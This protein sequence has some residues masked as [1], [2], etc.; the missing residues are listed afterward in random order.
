MHFRNFIGIIDLKDGSMRKI[1][2]LFL[3][4]ILCM[5]LCGC[6]SKEANVLKNNVVDN[7]YKDIDMSKY[8]N[9]GV[10]D[11]GISLTFNITG[12]EPFA[13]GEKMNEIDYRAYMNGYNWEA[14]LFHYLSKH[15][16]NVLEG[17]DTDPE[18]GM[19]AGYYDYSEENIAK[20]KEFEKIIIHLLENEDEIYAF[21][22]KEV[23]NI[24]WD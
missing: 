23:E 14:F 18:A 21:L 22:K 9:V 19:F 4:G 24:D 3:M 20:A 6:A 1:L 16:P 12:D 7:N 10:Y 11:D 8:V 15:N 13:I 17:F 2:I 5:E